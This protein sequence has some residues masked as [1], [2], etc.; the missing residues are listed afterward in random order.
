[1]NKSMTGLRVV[2]VLLA[3]FVIFSGLDQAL[4][5]LFSMGWM[6]K[7]TYFEVVNQAKFLQADNH[8]RFLGGVWTGLGIFMLVA[9]TDLKKYQSGLNLAFAMVFLGGLA[10]FS[11]MN[12]E[13]LL[14]AGVLW[15]VVVEVVGMP[16][17]YLWLNRTLPQVES[18]AH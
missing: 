18:I 13:V 10:R 6:E 7:T 2:F 9:A 11:Q 12:V 8:H 3:A 14:S 16:L 5:G 4:G 17:L 15:A 1:M